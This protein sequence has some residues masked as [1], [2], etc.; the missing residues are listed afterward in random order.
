MEWGPSHQWGSFAGFVFFVKSGGKY[1]ETKITFMQRLD[2]RSELE[3]K[4]KCHLDTAARLWLKCDE[5]YHCGVEKFNGLCSVQTHDEL[6]SVIVK[7]TPRWVRISPG[8]SQ[9]HKNG[10]IGI[11]ANFV[12]P[13]IC[14]FLLYLNIMMLANVIIVSENYISR[15]QSSLD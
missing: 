14:S 1:Q 5:L 12:I 3:Y 8:F 9:T 13:Y 7:P 10:N 11:T 2:W 15:L 6:Y 4:R